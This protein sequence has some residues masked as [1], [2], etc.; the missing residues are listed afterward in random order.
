MWKP[1]KISIKNLFSH[2][3]TVFVFQNGKMTLFVGRNGAGK[4][5]VNEAISLAITGSVSRGVNKSDFIREGENECEVFFEL[6]NAVLNQFLFIKRTVYRNKTAQLKIWLDDEEVVLADINE[7]EKYLMDLFGFSQE[8]YFNYFVI[9]QGNRN[10]FFTAGDAK[11]KETVNRFSNVQPI[12]LLL[13]EIKK[14]INELNSEYFTCQQEINTLNGKKMAYDEEFD[15]LEQT[16]SE[17]KKRRINLQTQ[18]LERVQQKMQTLTKKIA[19]YDASVAIKEKAAKALV[20]KKVDTAK[21]K[22]E[23]SG[24]KVQIQE[25]TNELNEA[26]KIKRKLTAESGA[27]L[28]CPHCKFKFIPDSEYTPQ[29]ITETLEMLATTITEF[30]EYITGLNDDVKAIDK[31]VE[32]YTN[33]S[34]RKRALA[35]EVENLKEFKEQTNDAIKDA[36]RQ[37][38]EIN[39]KIEAIKKES[40]TVR[41]Q[42]LKGKIAEN[43]RLTTDIAQKQEA[44]L[45]LLEEK[46]MFEY[47]FG[48]KGFK[49]FL[50]RQSIKVIQDSCN[51]YL[52]KFDVG[53]EIVIDGYTT[54]KK[55]ELRDKIEISILRD[56]ESKGLF[57]KYSGGEQNRVDLCGIVSIHSLINESCGYGKGLDLLIIDENVAYLD[58]EGQ[59]EIINILSKVGITSVLIMHNIQN[60]PYENKVWVKKENK[61]SKIYYNEA[62]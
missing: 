36:K 15:T 50:A 46:K 7:K 21:L 12:D 25:A 31:R 26:G 14:E 19:D 44:T 37:L 45:L 3:N 51:Y 32:A 17:D 55:G 6:S 49:S 48:N 27:V 47:H 35:S 38:A 29:Q 10:S 59:M 4:S 58:T 57:K 5:A 28:T 54:T 33:E 22:E 43:N 40:V 8:D 39:D 9:G 20:V 34:N 61:I 16:F 41:V 13:E 1:E 52:N 53:L 24:V 56:G 42:Q 23:K 60:V 30:E 62:A 18:E 11:Q 2:D